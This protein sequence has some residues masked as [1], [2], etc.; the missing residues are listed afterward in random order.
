MSVAKSATLI[1]GEWLELGGPP[2]GWLSAG[3]TS[4]FAR[5]PSTGPCAKRTDDRF[6]MGRA[7][8]DKPVIAVVIAR[9]V[10]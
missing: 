2:G 8:R 4:R 5:T 7:G 1:Y 6:A 3:G 10:P 9:T